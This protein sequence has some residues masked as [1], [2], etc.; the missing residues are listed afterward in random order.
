MTDTGKIT[1]IHINQTTR[2]LIDSL[3]EHRESYDEIIQRLA[4]FYI[5]NH[6]K[7]MNLPFPGTDS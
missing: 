5:D 4:R 7:L 6:G 1:T 2:A 3:G